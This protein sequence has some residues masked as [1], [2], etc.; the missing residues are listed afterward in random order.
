MKSLSLCI[1]QGEIFG[2]LGPNGAGKTTL[3]SM[4]TGVISPT[5]GEA[6]IGGNS[7]RDKIDKVHLNIGVCP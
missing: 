5:S 6:W 3:I 4:L 2:L 7:I 1:E